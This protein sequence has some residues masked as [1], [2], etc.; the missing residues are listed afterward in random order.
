M[1]SR[2]FALIAATAA[3]ATAVSACSGT[4]PAAPK[5]WPSAGEV[6]AAPT[7]AAVKT[8]A[9]KDVTVPRDTLSSDDVDHAQFGATPAPGIK[10]GHRNAD[11]TKD[12]CTIGPAVAPEMSPSAGGFLTAGHCTANLAPTPQYLQ[13]DADGPYTA[14]APAIGAVNA[15]AVDAAA[16]WTTGPQPRAGVAQWPVAGVLTEDGV[17]ALVRPGDPICV[18]GARTGIR[19]GALISADDNGRIRYDV[20]TREGDSGAPVFVVDQ[21][22][23]ATLIGIHK[24]GNGSTAVATYLDGALSRLGVKALVD[25]AVAIDPQADPGYSDQRILAP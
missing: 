21:N 11:G 17:R 2:N 16:I 15:G 24:E 1:S 7:S 3:A 5:P 6:A 25:P 14:F 10:I 8:P 19:C 20:P 22:G 18:D 9:W 12:M 4:A 23:R 13:P